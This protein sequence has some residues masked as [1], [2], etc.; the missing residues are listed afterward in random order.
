MESILSELNPDHNLTSYF[1]L[2]LLFLLP[3][4]LRLGLPSGLLNSEF[5]FVALYIF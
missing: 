3:S 2:S 5:A 4:H 1:F